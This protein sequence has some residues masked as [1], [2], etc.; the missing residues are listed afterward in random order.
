MIQLI[1]NEN[2]LPDDIPI[3]AAEKY[4]KTIPNIGYGWLKSDDFFIPFILEKRFIFKRLVFTHSP[5]KI[6]NKKKYDLSLEKSFL[7]NIVTYCKNLKIDYI[8]Q[9]NPNVLFSTYPE[10][11]IHVKFG[12]YIIDLRLTLE[13]LFQNLH[14]K[15]RNVIKKAQKDG[16]IIKMGHDLLNDFYPIYKNTLSRQKLNYTTLLELKKMVQG[17]LKD[18]CE[19]FIAEKD[20]IVQGGAFFIFQQNQST[21]YLLGASL[22]NPHIGSLNLLHWEAISYF[23]KI[24]VLYYNFV[25]ARISPIK[26][27]KQEGIQRFKSRFGSSFK[28]GYLWKVPINQKKYYLFNFISKLNSLLRGRKHRGDIIDDELRNEKK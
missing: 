21:Y 6:S 22:Q 5:I 10:E 19:I 24:G 16:V 17:P 25:G 15:H 13:T 2:L 18:N 23:K 20:G 3:T 14:S 8:S 28:E 1:R 9:P 27:S 26:G 12:T 7:N 4:L 11:S